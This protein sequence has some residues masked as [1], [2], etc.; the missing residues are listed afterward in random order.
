MAFSIIRILSEIVIDKAPS[1][2]PS[3]MMTDTIRVSSSDM[4]DSV[5]AIA[6][7]IP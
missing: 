5:V 3:P 4:S 6:D 7:P 1:P 2:P